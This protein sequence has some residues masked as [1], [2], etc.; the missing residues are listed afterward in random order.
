MPA[1]QSRLRSPA[2]V[3][4]LMPRHYINEEWDRDALFT[5]RN[6]VSLEYAADPHWRRPGEINTNHCGRGVYFLD[7]SGHG[8][9]LLTRAYG[10]ESAESP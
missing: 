3:P 1:G 7:P 10:S 2:R 9:E 5:H 6:L 4:N 8:M